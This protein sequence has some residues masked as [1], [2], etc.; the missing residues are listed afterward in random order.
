VSEHGDGTGKKKGLARARVVWDCQDSRVDAAV[1]DTII[2]ACEH[3][4]HLLH[5]IA[6]QQ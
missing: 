5:L 6:A 4:G 3:R 1:L 2:K